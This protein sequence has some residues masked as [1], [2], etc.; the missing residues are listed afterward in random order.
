MRKQSSRYTEIAMDIAT[1]IINGELGVGDRIS[2]RS[3]LA[4]KYNVS[5]ETIRRAVILLK[6]YGAVD[7]APK[8]GI[9]VLS[10]RKALEY[11]TQYQNKTSFVE[12]KDEIHDIVENKILLDKQLTE[13]VN[14]MID[15]LTAWRD[16][17]IV[18]SHEVEILE[19]SKLIGQS[20][21]QSDFWKYTG[22]TVIGIKRDGDNH[23]SPG[24]DWV[25]QENDT[26]VFVG[27]GNSYPRVID[28]VK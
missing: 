26:I 19:N 8:S 6:D 20:V 23:L 25:F 22:A 4:T 28:F 3:T 27:K 14:K 10:T 17:G 7:S 13:K 5:P 11:I 16:V 18:Y 21:S 15:Q 9:K 24:P 2:G 12:L 1:M